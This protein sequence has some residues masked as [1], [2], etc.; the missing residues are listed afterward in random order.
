MVSN[1]KV[2]KDDH[3]IYA[4]SNVSTNEYAILVRQPCMWSG[5]IQSV[6]ILVTPPDNGEDGKW[7]VN[8]RLKLH[9][10]YVWSFRS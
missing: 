6:R 1:T 3:G 9:D 10:I 7:D 4:E 2:L 5:G 8:S